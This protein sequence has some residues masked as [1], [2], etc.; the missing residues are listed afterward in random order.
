MYAIIV[1]WKQGE[2]MT[3]LKFMDFCAGI[4]GGRL[5]L[6]NS[7]LE[8]VAFSE[9]DADA[10]K[11]YRLFYDKDEKNYGDLTT[12]DIKELPDFDLLIGGFPCQTFSIVGK[13]TGFQD[14]RGMII[15]SL[16]EIMKEK[17]VPYFILEN[18]KGLTN[19]DKGNTL[20]TITKLLEEA[21][22]RLYYKVLNSLDYGVPQMRERI[23][24]VGIRNDKLKREFKWPEK[25]KTKS[26][27]TFLCDED[28]EILP[29]DN[30][31]FVKYLN[32]K[33][34]KD[35]F[36]I[37]E[38]LNKDYLVLD[39]RQSDLRLYENKVPT[40]RTGRHG[41][42]YVKNKQLHKISGYEG[43]LLQG[44]PKKLA[45]KAKKEKINSNKL[46]SQAGNA[47]TV[48]VINAIC[49]SLIECT[50]EEEK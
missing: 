46:L 27:K 47:M 49:N 31:T 1:M 12:L 5:G 29:V 18:V 2:K 19:H 22:Y 6:I 44:F 23:Y 14:Q 4:G 21:G 38:I 32:N 9:I 15:Y 42:L 48:N 11:T 39:T 26:I 28:T 50:E 33:Y 13:R 35:K 25:I 40:L 3:K 43:L 30:K 37:E 16:V 20:K 34:N 45:E 41:I 24:F 36:N 17:N 10:E 8:C 7:G